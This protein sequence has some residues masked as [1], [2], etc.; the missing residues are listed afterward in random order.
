MLLTDDILQYENECLRLYDKYEMDRCFGMLKKDEYK[1]AIFS[2]K[3]VDIPF[4]EMAVTS[5]CNLK[6]KYCSNLNPYLS[7]H[8]H[9]PL[10]S[11]MQWLDELLNS[12]D[13]VYRL[14]IHG[15]EPL[16]Y[17]E[18]DQFLSY[19]LRQEKI[20]NV[21][22]STNGTVIPSQKVL[23]QMKNKKFEIHVSGYAFAEKQAKQLCELF[24]QEHINFYYFKDQKWANLGDFTVKRNR[25]EKKLIDMVKDC[26]MRKC[27]S[28]YKGCLYPCSF[29]AS[30]NEIKNIREG[31]ELINLENPTKEIREFFKMS[32]FDACQY[33]DGVNET[34]IIPA[35]Q[36]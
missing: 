9:F 29:A 26:N 36:I 4:V 25:D 20:V 23:N 11:C 16:L 1:E 12:V 5:V 15:G 28:Y 13:L 24:E 35:E 10:E 21:R 30:R 22:I 32:Y 2:G 18:L 27:T 33:C 7:K 14:K 3:R 34:D 8:E 19:V 6:C 17:P 31:L